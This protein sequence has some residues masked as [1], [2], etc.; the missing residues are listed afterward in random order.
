VTSVRD[1]SASVT[2]LEI[3]DQLRRRNDLGIRVYASIRAD[4]SMT[5]SDIAS[6]DALRSRYTDDPLFKTGAVTLVADAEGSDALRD[7]VAELDGR[8]WQVIIQA[9]GE[10]AVRIAKDAVEYASGRNPTPER[11]RRHK[12]EEAER[13]DAAAVQSVELASLEKRP[14]GDAVDEVTREAAWESFDE[15]RKGS[16]EREMLADLVILTRDLFAA[17][18]RPVDV[19]VAVTI[20]DGRVVYTRP[21]DSND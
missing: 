4:V 8:G 16:I 15:H 21:S 14:I 13:T 20:F 7:M 5:E 10:E 6:L 18:L 11:E 17:R 19:D 1:R 12:I 3:Y 2:D 9:I